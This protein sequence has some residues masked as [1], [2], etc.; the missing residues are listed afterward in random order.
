MAMVIRTAFLAA[1]LSAA[2]TMAKPVVVA[3]SAA[4]HDFQPG[5]YQITPVDRES[6][7]AEKPLTLCLA[8]INALIRMRHSGAPHCHDRFVQP[9]PD[10]SIIIYSCS[11]HGWGRTEI[12][13]RTSNRY[14]LDTQGIQGNEP[15][16]LRAEARRIGDCAATRQNSFRR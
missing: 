13:P 15:F 11:S 2:P 6:P 8:D 10:R 16:A 12:R 14:L 5:L 9:G 7:A 1:L 3:A 4:V